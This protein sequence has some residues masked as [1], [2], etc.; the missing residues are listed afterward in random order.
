[1]QAPEAARIDI[2]QYLINS[3]K[4]TLL[5]SEDFQDPDVQ[6]NWHITSDNM[7]ATMLALI[8]IVGQIENPKVVTVSSDMKT[9]EI[10]NYA[11]IGQ[12]IKNALMQRLGMPKYYAEKLSIL[13]ERS[14]IRAT[15]YSDE[16]WQVYL[17]HRNHTTN[18]EDMSWIISPNDMHE[19][20]QF[21]MQ[22]IKLDC[23]FR[24]PYFAGL[25]DDG[26]TIY[27]D[28]D[29]PKDDNGF[30]AKMPIKVDGI[31]GF[32]PLAEYIVLHERVEGAMMEQSYLEQLQKGRPEIAFEYPLE[33]N[34][35]NRSVYVKARIIYTLSGQNKL[36]IA[37]AVAPS[38][39]SENAALPSIDE[40]G[41]RQRVLP[42]VLGHQIAERL[43]RAAIYAS[44]YGEVWEKQYNGP[45]QEIIGDLIEE[46]INAAKNNAPLDPT[47]P[48]LYI[49]PYMSD[50]P[51]VED[52]YLFK[53]LMR[54]KPGIEE[55]L[56]A[57]MRAQSVVP[58]LPSSSAITTDTVVAVTPQI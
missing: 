30:L 26:K 55:Q 37:Y 10:N 17:A 20:L 12:W 28:K 27:F 58:G 24:V 15:G 39:H 29:I 32:M 36:N 5:Q 6:E 53:H 57:I 51:K 43:E 3:K 9:L 14:T 38:T 34:H 4:A 44:G 46:Y 47:P 56:A 49:L 52:L 21:I 7:R 40:Q 45:V 8:A 31:T 42:Y 54:S 1:M 13:M 11:R 33:F 48:G 19:I 41:K 23:S 22:G 16:D 25:S 50:D 18:L 2:Q 35:D